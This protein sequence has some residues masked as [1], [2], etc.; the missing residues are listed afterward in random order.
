[1]ATIVLSAVGAAVGTSVGGGILGL[2]SVVIGRAVGAIAGSLIDQ[3][4]MGGGSDTVETGQVDRFRL[5]GVSEGAVVRRVFGAMRI[6]GQV[7]WT[8]PVR[9][10]AIVTEEGSGG[11]GKGGMF[12]GGSGAGTTAR[13]TEYRHSLSIAIALCEGEI[14]RVGRVWADG[15]EVA[16]ENLGIRVYTGTETQGPDP[17]IE[18]VEGTGN[19]PGYRGTA[20]VVI[21]DLDITAFGNR[22]P[23]FNFE[24][25]RPEGPEQ[26]AEIA[27]GTR[28][29]AIIPGTGEY[30]LATSR[31]H[32]G[33]RFGEKR[34]ANENTPLGKTDFAASLDMLTGEL[35]N[36]ESGSL[37]VCWFGDDLR[38]GQC[39]VA[40]K[41][42]KHVE[43]G[44][45]MPWRVA[46][47]TRSAAGLVPLESGRPV[48]GGTPT[49]QSVIEAITALKGAGKAVTFYPF[50][51]MTQMAGNGLADPWT[52]AAGQP[53]L[54]WR[55]R[56]TLSAAPG[57]DGSPDGT[58]AATAQVAAFFGS[59][60]P[61]DFSL[62]GDT[63]SYHGPDEWSYRRFI[64]HYAHLCAAAGG[65]EAFL[66]GSE[67]R[68]LTQ[69]REP[70]G[71]FPAVDRLVQLAADV[72]AVL[73]PEV[74]IS[75]AADWSEYFGY[76][77]QDGSGDLRFHLDKLWG[78]DNIDFIG[79]DNYM[80][81]SDWRDGP[82]HADAHWGSIYNLDYLKANILGGEG[83]D[84]FYHAPE[85]EALQ[86]RTA[87][88]DGAHGEPWVWRYKDLPN[89]WRN[90]HHERIGGVRQTEPT[91]WVPGSKPI[92]FTEIGCAAID[93]GTNQ[94]N[95][96]LD[97]KS[98]ESKLP[99]YSSGQ[100][101]DFIQMQYLRALNE[102]WAD[103]ANNPTDLETGVQ[104]LDM[105]RA[106]V[107]AWDARPFP[108]FPRSGA[109]WSDG[110]NYARG[111]WLNGR[112]TNRSLASVV[113]EVCAASG[114]APVDTA[115][116][117]G[118]VRGYV[119][120]AVT[121]GRNALQPLMLAYG[122]EAAEREGMLRFFSRT[123]LADWVIDRDRLALHDEIEGAVEFS[124]APEAEVAGRVRLNFVEAGR[125][126][127]VR[128]A[129]AIHPEEPTLAVSTSEM[130]LLL[131]TGEGRAITERWLA[132]ARVA[133]DGARFALPP[134]GLGNMAGDVV[135]LDL[136]EG[137][138]NFRLDHV[139]QGEVALVQAVRVEPS[140]FEPV[141]ALDLEADMPA[142]T[143]PVPVLPL[144]LDLP[145]LRG[146]EIAHAPYLAVTALPWPGPVAVYR[147]AEDDGYGFVT[148]LGAP[149]R[150]GVT[151]TV[152]AR[153]R[154]GVI[155]RGPVL[156]VRMTTGDLASASLE[157]VLNGANA[158]VIGDGAPDN[159]EVFQFT[160]AEL[161]GEG[162]WEI[163]GRLRGQ[164]GC[165]ATMPEVWPVGSYVVLLDS[166]VVQLPQA[167]GQRG[168]E[169]HYRIGPAARGYDDATYVHEVH[170]FSGVGLRPYAPVHLRAGWNGG[171]LHVSWLRRTRI[172]G[173]SW[174]AEE[175]PLGETQERYRVRVMAGLDVLREATVTAQA[176]SYSAAMRAADSVELP[177]AVEVAQVSEVWG[178]GP[179]R[180]IEIAA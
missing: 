149:A 63:I 170:A 39:E 135:E 86:R 12:G 119:I 123:G 57:R 1:M 103:P 138:G 93:K 160:T 45:E 37:V 89:W 34:P 49:D 87:I 101:D 130:P 112:A 126:Y 67:M 121:G 148:R 19:V 73:G 129:E 111:H 118:L 176:W 163:S 75:Y 168:L 4:I 173:D 153:A 26:P 146:D 64:L 175:V 42:E 177:F 94:P 159:W 167:L 30:A 131:T 128:A 169:R 58:A 18:A 69:I 156:R 40:P 17:K 68:G 13:T 5:T 96:F 99:K 164:A 14:T 53:A 33:D 90:A 61:G 83:Y 51:L 56:I 79:I 15:E 74:K 120:D 35:P 28:A 139:E 48:Y 9:E 65:V 59:A 24:V 161:V 132:E 151:E 55:G 62:Q 8:S 70:G 47:I 134:S 179:F 141:E 52:G 21:E 23:V 104:M 95:K 22:V 91:D 44:H 157:R 88:T 172:D 171:D 71:S 77:P 117:Y 38:C 108:W 20:Y 46:G 178:A 127:G 124:R 116:L 152:L 3:K 41:V 92:W 113:Q 150:V 110:G 7:I 78:D 155:D 114:L 36:L 27:R 107:W 10:H 180:R 11:S 133:R 25:F 82:D 174:F 122:F 147:A 66:I 137:A 142:F 100:R 165:D 80:P 158:A 145:L 16:A 140:V 2:S 125:D 29:V 54:P 85:A 72:R 97:P 98:S 166:A 76:H 102:F 50:I 162:L 6:G 31:V 60:Q 143:P 144:F 106:H 84:W 136:P 43:D 109:L 154:P 115:R 81:L 105:S 32:Y